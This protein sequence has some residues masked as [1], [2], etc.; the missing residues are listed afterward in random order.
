VLKKIL[1]RV[2]EIMFV[3][4]SGVVSSESWEFTFKLFSHLCETNLHA[5]WIFSNSVFFSME[6][7][8]FPDF[9]KFFPSV[10]IFLDRIF[11]KP[12]QILL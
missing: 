1:N 2:L 4:V 9:P 12:P 3:I 8:F 7:D 5:Q 6:F 11:R 10:P